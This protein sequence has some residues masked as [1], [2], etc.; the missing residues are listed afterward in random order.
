M[1]DGPLGRVSLNT[2]AGPGEERPWLTFD[3]DGVP[4]EILPS[5]AGA[6]LD[7]DLPAVTGT[8]NGRA[9]A[10]LT[11]RKGLAFLQWQDAEAT[12]FAIGDLC[13]DLRWDNGISGTVQQFVDD[14]E[15]LVARSAGPHSA[16]V[17]MKRWPLGVLSP[18]LD[19]AGVSL[20][21]QADGTVKL[22]WKA[23]LPLALGRIRLDVPELSIE[24][25][26]G[27]HAIQGEFRLERG[28]MG[29]DQALV[30]DR[31]ERGPA[32]LSVLHEGIRTG[33][34]TSESIL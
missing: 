3:V 16:V 33:T 25:T 7:L 5:W 4:A 14:V 1:L 34:M 22:D 31:E 29:M 18:L 11:T 8:L 19:K 28:F 13:L 9:Q 24:A 30:T 26:G 6:T 23:D 10:D 2:E 15:V 32:E 12:P 21:G 27:Q 20:R 17:E